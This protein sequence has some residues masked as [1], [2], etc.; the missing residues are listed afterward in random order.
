MSR[1]TPAIALT[2]VEIDPVQMIEQ[3]AV[4]FRS[5]DWAAFQEGLPLDAELV[6]GGT[7]RFAGHYV[8]RP[9]VMAFIAKLAGT[10]RPDQLRIEQ[11]RTNDDGTLDIEITL[12]I[13]ALGHFQAQRLRDRVTIRDGKAARSELSA[14][15]DQAA[16][17]QLLDAHWFSTT[18]Q[19]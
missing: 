15:G 19:G 16:L 1:P 11:L 13:R 8:G 4:A 18:R 12:M 10:T 7:S 3:L 17:D 2:G 5:R 14:A 6:M 9:Q